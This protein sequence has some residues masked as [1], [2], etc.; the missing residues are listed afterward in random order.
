MTCAYVPPPYPTSFP[1]LFE[2]S[3]DLNDPREHWEIEVLDIRKEF[4]QYWVFHRY[5]QWNDLY[6][7]EFDR[8]NDDNWMYSEYGTCD[9]CDFLAEELWESFCLC[10]KLSLKEDV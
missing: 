2:V 4:D 8:T 6:T 5:C 7:N 10:W 9:T 1:A 3:N